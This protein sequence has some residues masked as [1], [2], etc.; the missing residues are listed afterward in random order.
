MNSMHIINAAVIAFNLIVLLP[1]VW[2]Y[3]FD[4]VSLALVLVAVG[5]CSTSSY[6]IY[7]GA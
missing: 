3:G 4:W 5:L 1:G 7:M 6:M 2:R